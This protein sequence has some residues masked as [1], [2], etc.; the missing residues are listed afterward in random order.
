MDIKNFENH[1]IP[2]IEAGRTIEAVRNIIKTRQ[3]AKQDRRESLKETFKPI[4]DELE[5][6]DEGI[7][8]LK[9][10]LKDLKA[11]EGPP[12]LPAIEGP[13][14]AAITHDD[15]MTKEEQE[16]VLKRGYPDISS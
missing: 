12:A 14:A 5:K 16:S 6:I 11:I 9:D 1:I 15:Y 2:K 4:T 3:Y 8:K 10:E 7:Y 13:Q